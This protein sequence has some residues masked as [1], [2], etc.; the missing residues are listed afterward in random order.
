[1]G[2]RAI[3]GIPSRG[4]LRCMGFLDPDGMQVHAL[5]PRKAP[6]RRQ[7]DPSPPVF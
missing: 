5:V 1:M 3:F 2:Y 7:A 6:V 4:I